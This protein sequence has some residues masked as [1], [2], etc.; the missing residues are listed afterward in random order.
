MMLIAAGAAA[1]SFA[2]SLIGPGVPQPLLW[3]LLIV[4]GLTAVGW[5][6][7]NMTF[8]AELAGRSASATA[9]GVNL[10]GSYL[11]I[12]IGPPLFGLLVDTTGS[13]VPAFVLAGCLGLVAFGLV[14]QI[15]VQAE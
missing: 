13:Y 6:G 1:C 15:R 3:G 9:A 4:T 5:N 10:T 7:I 11:G 2:L 12:L 14:S 8:V